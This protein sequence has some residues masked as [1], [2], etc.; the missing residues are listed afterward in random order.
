[1]AVIVN[2][3][4]LGA[5]GILAMAPGLVLAGTAAD[6]F[7]VT[8][9]IQGN[10]SITATAHDFGLNTGA[11]TANIDAQSSLDVTCTN[12][13]DYAVGLSTGNG[14]GATYAQRRMTNA[15]NAST[16][17]YSLYS[18]A[19]RTVVWD[20]SAN[21]VSGT[22]TGLAQSITVYGRVPAPQA[23]VTV[24]DYADSVVATVTF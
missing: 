6:T 23:N 18:D 1:M 11:I 22:G 24:G 16:V 14:A 7:P 20:E 8:L 12:G 13:T 3:K 21:E 5:A 4:M 10:C 9:T 2:K 17:N 19:A 15:A